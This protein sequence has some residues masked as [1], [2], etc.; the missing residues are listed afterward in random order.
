MSLPFWF[1]FFFGCVVGLA[2]ESWS[3]DGRQRKKRL[4]GC[5]LEA[6][7]VEEAAARSCRSSCSCS[8]GCGCG[9]G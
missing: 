4:P 8:C 5:Q 2:I 7:A 1:A 9:C 3:C 6:L